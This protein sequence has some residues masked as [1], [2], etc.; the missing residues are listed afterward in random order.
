MK[1]TRHG[2]FFPNWWP[3]ANMSND[4]L[5]DREVQ[6]TMNFTGIP[7]IRLQDSAMITSMGSMID[8]T[9]E[10]LGTTDAMVIATRRKLIKAAKQLRGAGIMPPA[11]QNEAAYRARS[12]SAVLPTGVN[13]KEAFA[14]WH[15]GR[16]EIPPAQGQQVQIALT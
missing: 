4:F 7:T 12:C 6:R 16:T 8:R 3:V 9:K 2:Q 1:E 14:D 15:S 13:W 5:M 11:S 10:H